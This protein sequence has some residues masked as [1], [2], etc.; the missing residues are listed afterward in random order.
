MA[1]LG[2][3]KFT[4]NLTAGGTVKFC[5]KNNKATGLNAEGE[6]ANATSATCVVHIAATTM[7]LTV[8]TYSLPYA[9]LEPK[10]LQ[11]AEDGTDH[12]SGKD[13]ITPSANVSAGNIVLE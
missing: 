1:Y 5:K 2:G 3:K 7:T 8:D 12:G 6:E 4:V 13:T 9:R 11:A 10:N